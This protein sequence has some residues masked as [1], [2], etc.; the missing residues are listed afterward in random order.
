[1]IYSA[2]EDA[3]LRHPLMYLLY[4]LFQGASEHV[5]LFGTGH[6]DV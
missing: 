3:I 1:M 5:S 6:T 4:G 2:L